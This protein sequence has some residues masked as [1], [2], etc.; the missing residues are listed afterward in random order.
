MKSVHF[1]LLFTLRIYK[2]YQVYWFACLVWF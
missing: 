1:L 2:F